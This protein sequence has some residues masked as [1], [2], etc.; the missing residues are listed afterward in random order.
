[1][2]RTS[3]HA[4]G[5][6]TT[7]LAPPNPSGASSATFS[8]ASASCLAHEIFAGDAHVD[9]AGAELGTMSAAD[10]NAIFDILGSR[11]ARRG[12]RARRALARCPD[13]RGRKRRRRSPA[14]ALSTARREQALSARPPVMRALPRRADDRSRSPRRP[15]AR[16][17]RRRAAHQPVVAAAADDRPRVG[18]A[19][20]TRLED[21]AG[22]IFEVAHES[23]RED[24]VRR[25]SGRARRGSR[26]AGRSVERRAKIEA[27]VR[28]EP[29]N[30]AEAVSGSPEIARKRRDRFLLLG[31]DAG[32]G[33]ARPVRG[34]GRRFRRRCGRRPWRCR[35]SPADLRRSALAP[36]WSALSSAAS[37]PD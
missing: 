7:T 31:A 22:V 14:G 37:T 12:S 17:D 6:A 32:A 28:R 23:G 25:S 20:I 16:A 21:E 3:I 24:E 30:C 13:Q 18:S 2:V 36:A 26:R 15:R 8:S 35:R 27:R 11:R 5:A 29:R 33:A 1:M 10:R 19:A 9:G 34:N 4:R